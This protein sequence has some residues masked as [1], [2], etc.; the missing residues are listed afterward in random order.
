MIEVFI[1]EDESN[2]RNQI[3]KYVENYI[4]IENFDMELALSTGDPE[5]LLSYVQ[6][7]GEGMA[8]YFLD[9][10]LKHP[11]LDG[12][13]LAQ[14]IREYDPRGFIVFITTHAELSYLTF[15][16][17]VEA[18]DYIIKDDF[19]NVR[20]RIFDCMKSVEERVGRERKDVGKYFTMKLEEK[21]IHELYDDIL[22]LET[23]AKAR[24]IILHAKDRQIEFY[25][26]MKGLD[27]KLDERFFRTHRSF[28]LNT[29]KIESINYSKGTI[30][31]VNGEICTLATRL[32]K[33]LREFIKKRT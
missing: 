19:E 32:G 25:G 31:V 15:T 11:R 20:N 9:V 22:F 21:V 6:F 2:Q 18:M 24:R 7:S 14:K 13:A 26:R 30:T 10:D 3:V 23:S 17:K 8:L 12:L 29:D 27:E 1:C 28:I 16:Y 5:E 4:M 33:E